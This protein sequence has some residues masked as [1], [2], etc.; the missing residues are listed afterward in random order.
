MEERTYEQVC[1]IT[2]QFLGSG[3]NILRWEGRLWLRSIKLVIDDSNQDFPAV[4]FSYYSG[5]R[6]ERILVC[7]AL[8]VGADLYEIRV[9]VQGRKTAAGG[10]V[11][12]EGKDIYVEQL[13]EVQR[14]IY[15]QPVSTPS[16][17]RGAA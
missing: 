7:I 15:G 10:T 3:P 4:G 8:N 12:F 1:E 14:W 2:R 17:A 6:D 16:D 5:D 9:V 13:S 11:L